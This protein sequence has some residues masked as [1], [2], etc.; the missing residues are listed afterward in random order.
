MYI[1]YK[2]RNSLYL[3]TIVRAN[4]DDTHYHLCYLFILQVLSKQVDVNYT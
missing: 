1:F 3:L 2:Q 4:W